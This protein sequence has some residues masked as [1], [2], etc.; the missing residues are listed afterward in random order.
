LSVRHWAICVCV[1]EPDPGQFVTR[2]RP[3]VSVA[4]AFVRPPDLLT[5]V[6]PS[7]DSASAAGGRR[8]GPPSSRQC[9][10]TPEPFVPTDRKRLYRQSGALHA[11]HP[12]VPQSG[13]PP[14]PLSSA[15]YASAGLRSLHPDDTGRAAARQQPSALDRQESSRTRPSPLG[16]RHMTNIATAWSIPSHAARSQKR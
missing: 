13:A 9:R 6:S 14:T 11:P 12:L 1:A 2:R 7:A 4:A 5:M 15:A 8:V 16:H 3:G 10:E